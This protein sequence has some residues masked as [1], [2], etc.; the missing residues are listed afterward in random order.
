MGEPEE[1]G[2][3]KDIVQVVNETVGISEDVDIE[4]KKLVER[5][6]ELQKQIEEIDVKRRE[7]F[8][9]LQREIASLLEES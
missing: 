6:R 2:K 9:S 7:E 1:K 8:E 4:L 3:G 5:D